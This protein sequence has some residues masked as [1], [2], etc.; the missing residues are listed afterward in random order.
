MTPTVKER[1]QQL[2]ATAPGPLCDDCLTEHLKLNQRQTAYQTCSEMARSGT[3]RGDRAT[4][5]RCGKHK[6]GNWMGD[7]LDT[8]ARDREGLAAADAAGTDP[9]R[10]WYWEGNVQ[11]CIVRHLQ[12]EGHAI[13]STADTAA[14]TPG[15][16]VAARPGWRATPFTSPSFSGHG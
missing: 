11:A 12:Q 5:I 3:I 2:L 4:C 1:I 7:R 13:V 16:D 10:P 6:N 14:R 15:K 9:S 8:G